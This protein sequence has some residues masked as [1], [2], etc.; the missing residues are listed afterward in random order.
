MPGI[1]IVQ[2]MPK[3]FTASFAESLNKECQLNVC[4]AGDGDKVERGKVLI[5]PGDQHMMLKLVGKQYAVAMNSGEL[6]NRHR[7][8]VDV[9]FRS[10]ANLVG[11]KSVGVIL[12]G[13]G[14]DGAMGLSEMHDAGSLTLAQDEDSC[15]VYGM[16]RKAVECGAVDEIKNLEGIVKRLIELR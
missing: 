13:M 5:S 1:V 10:V 3:A 14:D 6:V 7:P 9:L 4:E 12:T 15:V 11:K 8:S 2:H 16:P